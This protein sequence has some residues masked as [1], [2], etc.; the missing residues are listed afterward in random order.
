LYLEPWLYIW[1]WL[2]SCSCSATAYSLLA[3]MWVVQEFLAEGECLARMRVLTVSVLWTRIV[4]NNWSSKEN[5]HR[6]EVI[7]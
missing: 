3:T 4:F 5:C 6:L 7:L 1:I 2:V